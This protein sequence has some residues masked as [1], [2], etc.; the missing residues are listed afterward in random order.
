MESRVVIAAKKFLDSITLSSNDV[1]Y[2]GNQSTTL[3]DLKK[4]NKSN[5]NLKTN[6]KTRKPITTF[7]GMYNFHISNTVNKIFFATKSVRNKLKNS[8]IEIFYNRE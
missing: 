6:I 1:N 3:K 4:K 8:S 5:K 7:H 2:S